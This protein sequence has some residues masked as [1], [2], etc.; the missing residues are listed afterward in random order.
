M[1]PVDSIF[2]A[3]AASNRHTIVNEDDLSYTIEGHCPVTKKAWTLVVNK[4]GYLDWI[5]GSLIQKALPELS[6][7]QRELLLSGTSSE[8]WK[9]LFSGSD[10]D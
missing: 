6:D 10:E 2:P 9:L 1:K 3:L 5:R 7:D 4:E 8:G